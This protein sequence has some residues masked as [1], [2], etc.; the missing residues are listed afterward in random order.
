MLLLSLRSFSRGFPMKSNTFSI[1][2]E[3]CFKNS[4]KF[5]KYNYAC[6]MA[7]ATA[8]WKTFS[9]LILCQFDTASNMALKQSS[10]NNNKNSEVLTHETDFI[11]YFGKL[12]IIKIYRFKSETKFSKLS[13]IA[14]NVFEISYY[15]TWTIK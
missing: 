14:G 8:F 10:S 3:P 5:H 6:I 7:I 13:V 2:I 11:K 12:S 15:L 1:S 4:R 9:L